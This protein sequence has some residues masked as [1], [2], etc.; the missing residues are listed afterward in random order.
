M[1]KGGGGGGGCNRRILRYKEN[2]IMINHR[3]YVAGI[4]KILWNGSWIIAH[5]HFWISDPVFK[6]Q[7]WLVNPMSSRRRNQAIFSCICACAR[8]DW[9]VTCATWAIDQIT[10]WK[11]EKMAHDPAVVD[12]KRGGRCP[13]AGLMLANFYT[14]QRTMHAPSAFTHCSIT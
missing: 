12:I 10:R 13:R 14:L 7:T 9:E 4:L 8:A 1:H 11:V 3:Y 5:L 6:A 2:V